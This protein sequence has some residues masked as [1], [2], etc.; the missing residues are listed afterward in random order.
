MKKIFLCLTLSFPSIITG[1]IGQSTDC[2]SFCVTN[3]FLD[4]LMPDI[5]NIEIYFDGT[6]DDFINYPFVS[7]VTD[8]QGDTVGTGTL[9]FFGHFGNTSQIYQ[10]TTQLD[11]IP[12]NFTANVWFRYDSIECQLPY[13]CIINNVEASNSLFDMSLYP[14]PATNNVTIYMSGSATISVE[15]YSSQGLLVFNQD[16]IT[17][18]KYHIETSDWIPGLYF[19]LLRQG[20]Q[21]VVL[22]LLIT[23]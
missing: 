16:R 18:N 23:R 11:A 22:H 9:N 13:P 8:M 12:E 20:G 5:M 3:I 17:G 7:Y 2:S 4:S 21:P 10:V 1:L 15:V 14:N 19:V 6:E